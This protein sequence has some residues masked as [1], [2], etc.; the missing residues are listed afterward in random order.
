MRIALAVV[1]GVMVANLAVVTAVTGILLSAKA[2]LDPVALAIYVALLSG[3]LGT[4]AS[5]G[6]LV[7][8]FYFGRTNHVAVG[9]VK[10][11]EER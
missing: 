11:S 2:P 9:G 10:G 8:G 7:I 3:A 1:G 4:L 6:S 5:L